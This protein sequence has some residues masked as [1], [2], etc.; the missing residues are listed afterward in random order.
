MPLH[1]RAWRWSFL[2]ALFFASL[3]L[4][5]AMLRRFLPFPE[6]EGIEPKL[7]WLREHGADYD[8]LFVG[9]SRIFW[10]VVPSEFDAV[11]AQAGRPTRSFNLAYQSVRPPEDSYVLEQALA[12]RQAPLRFVL[13]EADEIALR[14]RDEITG[15]ARLAYWH[16]LRRMR[17]LAGEALAAGESGAGWW[18]NLDERRDTFR[19]FDSHLRP[20]LAW[21]TNLGRGETLLSMR[22]VQRDWDDLVGVRRDGFT[23][24]KTEPLSVRSAKQLRSELKKREESLELASE[25]S[26]RLFA[27][28]ERRIA[29]AGARMI[30]IIP[31]RTETGP[32]L[33]D[34][35]RFPHVL[36][37]D[38]SDPAR[39]PE[40]FE[41]RHRYDADHLNLTGAGVFTR[42][43]A[44]RLIEAR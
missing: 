27:D 6:I 17:A 38:F 15:T 34:P 1:F 16:D 11:M 14:I 37:L 29:A 42:L 33:P 21:A 39:Y 12:T 9:S 43:L 40:L 41:E 19:E 3:F 44:A 18:A 30:V 4:T 36:V 13:V 20:F 8:T 23:E 24:E 22:R 10:H 7:V 2:A 5:S 26:Q 25:A 31:P 35:K 28:M 32:F